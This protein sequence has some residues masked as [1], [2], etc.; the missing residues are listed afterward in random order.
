[1][2]LLLVMLPPGPP[3][4]YA[5]VTSQD[6]LTVARH[7]SG[8]AATL[9]PPAGRGVEVVAIAPA[10]R[11]AWQ[12]VAL[13]KG[14]GPGSARLRPALEGLLEDRLLEDAAR[15]HFALEPSARGGGGECWVALCDRAWL[16]AHLSAL[17]AAQRPVSRIVPETAPQDGPVS[18]LITGTADQPQALITGEGVEA[19]VQALPFTPAALALLPQ[20]DAG[21]LPED[22]AVQAE[23]AVAQMAERLLGGGVAL[24]PQPERLLLAGRSAWDLAQLDLAQNT[25]ARAGKRLASLWRAWLHER[26]WRPARWGLALALLAN[27]AGL[28][29]WAWNE[30][31]SLRDLRARI[32]AVLT[33]TF[34]QVRAVVDAPVQMEREVAALRQATGAPSARDM[35]PMLA[36]LGQAL[37][38]R[39]EAGSPAAIEYDTGELTLKGLQLDGAALPDAAAHLRPL[40]YQA[41]AVEGGLRVSQAASAGAQP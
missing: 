2:S 17:E 1:M 24:L 5:Y 27:L 40:G 29:A 23:P 12:R 33:D 4:V 9:L 10:A 26:V 13:P 32:D 41:E 25:R 15:L 11:L 18:L 31:A 3:G 21:R 34:P 6:G 16:K 14:V 38:A 19:G 7:G 22:A 35:E 28:N 20:D 8:V 37:L 39:P 36:A 30:R